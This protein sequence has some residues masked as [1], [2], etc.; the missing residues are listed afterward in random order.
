[1]I[2]RIELAR[3]AGD[4]V[5]GV[6]RAV[7]RG[8]PAGWGEPVFDKLEA[9]LARAMMSIP[10]V[11]GV[12][13]GMGFAGTRLTGSEHN[14][15][16]YRRADGSIGT[17]T[18]RSGA[19]RAGS[20]TASRSRS[21]SRSSF[22]GDD[23][24]AAGDGRP[25]RR[26]GDALAFGGATI[27]AC[28][29]GRC[30]SSRRCSRSCWRITACGR[31]RAVATEAAADPGAARR[32]A[33]G[34]RDPAPRL[35]RMGPV[36][37]RLLDELGYD[38]DEPGGAP[39]RARRANDSCF[40]NGWRGPKG[41]GGVR[42][43]RPRWPTSTRRP[44]RWARSSGRAMAH[45]RSRSRASAAAGWSSST[46]YVRTMAGGSPTGSSRASAWS[47]RATAGSS[48]SRAAGAAAHVGLQAAGKRP[49][50]DPLST[51]R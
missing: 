6:V 32:G 11:K 26:A 51:R 28:C 41:S 30:R 2:E 29:R 22:D 39:W 21:G 10:A 38:P 20:R 14:D 18:N 7:A 1:M 37:A 27:R 25:R 31:P 46:T 35:P 44:C 12:E 15:L 5:G 49:I 3:K 43:R 47:A 34:C 36:T 45:G 42:P 40:P 13:N 50:V 17:R 48:R 33:R 9:E 24:A 16:F 23:H 19:S 4:S 8:V